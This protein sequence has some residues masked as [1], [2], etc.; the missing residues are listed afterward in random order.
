MDEVLFEYMTH[1]ESKFEGDKG[2]LTRK[3]VKVR[4]IVYIGKESDKLEESSVL[5]VRED[6]YPVY[7]SDE[8]KLEHYRKIIFGISYSEAEKHGFDKKNWRNNRKML[9]EGKVPKFQK[10]IIRALIDIRKNKM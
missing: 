6:G 10:R 2:I 5:G 1:P 9:K 3:H 8:T 7:Q 4:R